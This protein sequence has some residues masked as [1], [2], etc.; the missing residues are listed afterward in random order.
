M[1][2]LVVK[3]VPGEA[4]LGKSCDDAELVSPP[5]PIELELAIEV[6]LPRGT[7]L[8]RWFTGLTVTMRL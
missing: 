1:S 8:F 6:L 2:Y 7:T 3:L 4:G 5:E